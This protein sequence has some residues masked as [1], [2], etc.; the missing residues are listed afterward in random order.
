[1]FNVCTRCGAYHADKFIDPDGPYA[2][3]PECGHAQPFRR[4]PLLCVGGPSGGGKSAIC[5]VLVGQV[6]EAVF[7]EGDILWR[8]EFAQPADD[9]R[10]FFEM[11]LRVA[12]NVSQSG[13]PVVLFGAGMGVPSNIESCVERRYFS[14]V[15]YLALVCEDEVLAARLRER[16]AWRNAGDPEWIPD[17]VHFNQWFRQHQ[18]LADPPLT[19]VDTTDLSVAEAAG[20]VDGWIRSVLVDG[21]LR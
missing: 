21:G 16:P 13:R 2:L 15:H 7:L 11:W 17:Q 14:Q 4:L 8:P 3:C 19:L 20:Q 1:M 5:G 10:S 9:Y 6:D 18:A 12:K